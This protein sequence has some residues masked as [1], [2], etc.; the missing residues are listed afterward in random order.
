MPNKFIIITVL[1]F[2]MT[3]LFAQNEEQIEWLKKKAAIKDL[4]TQNKRQSSKLKSTIIEVEGYEVDH[5]DDSPAGGTLSPSGTGILTTHNVH[6][7][8][9]INATS[10]KIPSLPGFPALNGDGVPIL[11]FD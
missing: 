7:A 10:V 11:L 5:G 2:F 9:L 4:T 8:S 1:T 6:A 3:S